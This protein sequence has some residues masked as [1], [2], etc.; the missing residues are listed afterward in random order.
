MSKQKFFNPRLILLVTMLSF[1]CFHKVAGTT[2]QQKQKLTEFQHEAI[3]V[4]IEV[5]VRVFAGNDFVGDLQITDFEIYE[6]GVLQQVEAMYLVQ[7]TDISREESSLNREE[8]RQ[9]FAPQVKRNF[10]LMFE[11]P[12]YEAKIRDAISY[13][14]ENVITTGDRLIVVTPIKTYDFKQEALE[15]IPR[16]AIVE[17]LNGKL[18]NDIEMGCG[19]YRS[20]YKDYMD[21]LQSQFPLDLKLHM[22]KDKIRELKAIRELSDK[23]LKEF[24]KTLKAIPGQKHAFVFYKKELLPYPQLPMESLEYLEIMSELMGYLTF[25]PETLQRIYSDSSIA[26]HFLYVTDIKPD[27]LDGSAMLRGAYDMF[28]MS[29]DVFSAFKEMAN[30]TGGMSDSSAN[31]ASLVESASNASENY[32]LLYYTPKD[33]R[34][35]GEFKKIEVR[36]KRRGCRVIHRAGYLAD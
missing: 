32:Y 15:R 21:I 31:I 17:Q 22:L 9:K 3:A 5:P 27:Y 30:A 10:V 16:E 7:R 25:D 24:A 29:M 11:I 1:L 26:I 4:N 8:A 35:D 20:L 18:R 28:D 13:F 23:K 14:F 34:S 2:L 12:K 36:I 19:E 33:Y 6:D